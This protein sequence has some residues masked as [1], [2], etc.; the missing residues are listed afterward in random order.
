MERQVSITLKEIKGEYKRK[1]LETEIEV[2]V[3][4]NGKGINNLQTEI[5]FLNHM[6][7]LFSQHGF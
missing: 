2:K 6:L 3:D 7:S 1:S 5:Y 4:L